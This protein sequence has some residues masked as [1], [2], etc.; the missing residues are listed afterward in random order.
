MAVAEST[1]APR[2]ELS[3]QAAGVL[4]A[5]FVGS[6]AHAAIPSGMEATPGVTPMPLVA[7]AAASP[8]RGHGCAPSGRLSCRPFAASVHGPAASV[9]REQTSTADGC[10]GVVGE[11]AAARAEKVSWLATAANATARCAFRAAKLDR[12]CRSNCTDTPVWRAPTER[13]RKMGASYGR[14][15]CASTAAG[16]ISFKPCQLARI[17]QKAAGFTSEA[18]GPTAM[19]PQSSGE[20]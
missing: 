15:A 6:A 13:W 7:H 9:A 5:G 1:G 20:F 12:T 3:L 17:G 14:H 18:E 2:L 4:S 10:R 11:G 8:D 19:V 16:L